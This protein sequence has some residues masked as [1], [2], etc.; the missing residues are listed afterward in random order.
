MNAI[1]PYHIILFEL[2]VKIMN[3]INWR[4][5]RA[6]Q[7]NPGKLELIRSLLIPG[8]V[9]LTHKKY[10][11][12]NFFIPGYWKH[13]ALIISPVQVIEATG[14]GVVTRNIE[15]VITSVDDYAILSPRF[16]NIEIMCQACNYAARL[17]GKRYSYRF[18]NSRDEFYCSGFIYKV[19]LS[20]LYKVKALIE[21]TQGFKKFLNGSITTPNDIFDKSNDWALEWRMT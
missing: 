21:H 12:T 6:Y 16:C 7:C 1:K 8:M 18:S 17:L 19:Y 3:C 10:E 11:L 2:L 13:A 15:E 5:G 14:K 4:F 9:L 20:S